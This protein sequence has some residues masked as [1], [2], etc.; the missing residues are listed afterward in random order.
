MITRE[1]EAVKGVVGKL[2]SRARRL[3]GA[4][5][6]TLLLII[7]VLAA[8]LTIFLLA[9]ELA[10]REAKKA[11]VESA[12]RS[13]AA[14]EAS[15]EDI[16]RKIPKV[17]NDARHYLGNL[18]T[19]RSEVLRAED[20]MRSISDSK[21]SA[22]VL[23]VLEKERDRALG[24]EEKAAER[25]R[26]ASG[27]LEVLLDERKRIEEQR[28]EARKTLVEASSPESS[29]SQASMTSVLVSAIVTR[30][31]SIVL[32]L[33]L[34]QILVPLYRY[35]TRLAAYYEARGDSL[36]LLNLED[37]GCLDGLERL[38]SSLSPDS[39]TFGKSPSTPVEQ[40]MELAKLALS[41]EVRGGTS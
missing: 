34:V 16:N 9:G 33:F 25:E 11:L 39:V 29:S 19:A 21:S 36:E 8:G 30:I 12:R 2:R 13:L 37:L 1:Q 6:A 26:I 32:L 7:G 20:R 10:N 27:I 22:F 18:E 35:N 40:T 23:H 3:R 17:Q 38:V 31:S 4:A 24:M 41:R 5:T 28:V 14:V 15:L